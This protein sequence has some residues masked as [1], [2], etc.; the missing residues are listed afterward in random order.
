MTS[1]KTNFAGLPLRNPVIISS[2]GLT[3]SAEKNRRLEAAGAGAIVLKSVFEEQIMRETHH[4]VT[5]DLPEGDDYLS[6]YVRSHTLNNYVALIRESKQVCSIPIIASINCFS[7]DEWTEF[8]RIVGEA[9]AD[10]LE[11]NILSVQT[12]WDYQYGSFEQMHIDILRQIKKE[13]SIPVIMK[14]GMNLTNPIALIHQ[15]CANGADGVVL[16]NRFYHPDI[17]L[18]TLAYSSGEV[19]SH[20]GELANGL[21][22]TALASARVPGVDYA[23][24]GGVHSGEALIKSILAGASAVE[25]CSTIY[26]HGERIIGEMNARLE[27]WMDV[28]GYEHLYQ[29]RG[30]MNALVAGGGS[31]YERTQFLKYFGSKE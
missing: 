11:I 29:F 21:R 22:W 3:N 26:R 2:S 15:L 31:P 10:A 13:V 19:F 30:K 25:I 18:D 28:Q 5:N 8:A 16:F 1:L 27:Q 9:G 14:L 20:S 17:H 24:S 12:D 4:W 6:T 23:I 7:A